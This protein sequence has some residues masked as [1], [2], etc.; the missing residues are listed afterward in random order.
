V[1][2]K[3]DEDIKVK[4]L[5]TRANKETGSGPEF[6]IHIRMNDVGIAQIIANRIK[7]SF[8]RNSILL[9]D[10]PNCVEC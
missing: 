6:R 5:T 7:T 2:D 4:V 9:S 8:K 10:S 1:K 3:V